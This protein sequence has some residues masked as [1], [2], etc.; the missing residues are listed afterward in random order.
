MQ[1]ALSP[2]TASDHWTAAHGVLLFDT[3]I[4]RCGI[5]WAERGVVGVQLP[6]REEHRTRDM[7]LACVPGTVRDS[8]PPTTVQAAVDGIVALLG[9][10]AVD[11][12]FVALDMD[13]VPA[14][15][16]RVYEAARL[17]PPGTTATYGQVAARAGAPREARAVGQALG[18]NPFAIVVP[19][20]RVVP[21]D[22]SLGGFSAH[23]GTAMKHRLLAIEGVSIHAALTLF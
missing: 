8:P 16:R 10:E 23:G 19:C 9:G 22:G 14:F 18:R 7:L 5:A 6:E 21:A 13:R 12:S 20:H 1:T 2:V 17:I 4:G 3:A 11:L 15:D